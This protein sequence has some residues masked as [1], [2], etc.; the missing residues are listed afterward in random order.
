MS[1]VSEVHLSAGH[2]RSDLSNLAGLDGKLRVGRIDPTCFDASARIR[3]QDWERS[4]TR[5]Q[6]GL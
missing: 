1:A 3:G 2:R 4:L 6:L 5:E